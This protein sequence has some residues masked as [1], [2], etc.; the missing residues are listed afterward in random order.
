MIPL[1]TKIDA[2]MTTG[3]I[4]RY[5]TRHSHAAQ[6][7][8]IKTSA[9]VLRVFDS[10]GDKPCVVMSPDGPNVIEHYKELFD[11]LTPHLR[12]VC[13]DMP[14]FG[15]SAPSSNYGHS[16]D[17][18]ALAIIER[19][20]QLKVSQAMLAMSCANGF[21]ALR[22]AQL[23]PH[24]V[25]RLV[26]SQTPSIQAMHRWTDRVVPK[27]LTMP[28]LGQVVGRL[29]RQKLASSW[30]R[31]ALP[32][33][34]DAMP[35][36]QTARRALR[37]GGCFGLAGVV[38]GLLRE[39]V[40][41]THGTHTPC[42]VLWGTQDRSH[43]LTDPQAILRDVPQAEVLQFDDCGHFPDLENPLRFAQILLAMRDTQNAEAM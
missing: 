10:G 5:R 35:F 1:S 36:Q 20:D 38:Q 19:L 24:R 32:K 2:L 8:W 23:A 40:D 12:V 9:G 14:G 33:S 30:Y 31:I 37:C 4:E 39:S 25:L 6:T 28:F 16:L 15:F 11:L 18:A 43:R 42:T 21:Y 29:L 41:A 34:T 17:Q 27:L 3:V 22:V 7:L 13:F 26:L